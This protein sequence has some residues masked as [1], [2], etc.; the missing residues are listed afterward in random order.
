MK[1]LKGNPN[2]SRRKKKRV[3]LRGLAPDCTHAGS[4]YATYFI[5]TYIGRVFVVT[6]ESGTAIGLDSSKRTFF[7]Y[8]ELR[9]HNYKQLK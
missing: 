5:K 7:S 6:Y 1:R 2:N 4:I 9:Q 8:S 3:V